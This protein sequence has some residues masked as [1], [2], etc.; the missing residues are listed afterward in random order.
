MVNAITLKF[1]ISL[2]MYENMDMQLHLLIS[3]TMY[4]N[5]DMHLM[6]VVFNILI[7]IS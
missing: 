6:D 2:T 4:E 5:M 3:L 7:W 1:L